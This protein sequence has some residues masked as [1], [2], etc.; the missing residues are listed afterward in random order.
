MF[1]SFCILFPVPL[2]YNM[3]ES[4]KNGILFKVTAN[5]SHSNG[6][7]NQ[8][9][10]CILMILNHFYAVLSPSKWF[11]NSSKRVI[12]K[13][14]CLLCVFCND[15]I[16]ENIS[17][18]RDLFQFIEILQF[19]HVLLRRGVGREGWEGIEVELAS[20]S[21]GKCNRSRFLFMA[22]IIKLDYL[23]NQQIP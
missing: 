9:P 12:R 14:I 10:H 16:R 5:F 11:E 15:F 3:R 1:I 4:E 21:V 17:A 19:I 6:L 8:K 2:L 20:T 23:F 18:H 22:Q 7:S 13:L